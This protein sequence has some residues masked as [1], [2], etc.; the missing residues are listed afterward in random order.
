MRALYTVKQ[1]LNSDCSDWAAG[2]RW[3]VAA[4]RRAQTTRRGVALGT[5]GGGA[6]EEEGSQLVRAG[7]VMEEDDPGLSRLG[8]A[9]TGALVQLVG[10]SVVL[11]FFLSMTSGN[12]LLNL[13]SCPAGGVGG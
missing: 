7:V 5:S 3:N 4:L 9:A 6:S 1:K 10:V 12:P 8:D 11:A 13:P 2:H